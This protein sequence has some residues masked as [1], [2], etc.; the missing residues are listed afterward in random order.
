L[1]WNQE[2]LQVVGE[3]VPEQ[4]QNVGKQQ[5]LNDRLQDSENVHDIAVVCDFLV[6]SRMLVEPLNHWKKAIIGQEVHTDA[7]EPDQAEP[8]EVAIDLLLFVVSHCR[9][10]ELVREC[11]DEEAE[12]L[13][14]EDVV[15]RYL[16]ETTNWLESLRISVLRKERDYNLQQEE[17]LRIL[18]D[19]TDP[20]QVFTVLIIKVRL[21]LFE[22]E[23][24]KVEI[25]DGHQRG[26]DQNYNLEYFLEGAVVLDDVHWWLLFALALVIVR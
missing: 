12:E 14:V 16:L 2:L 25:E 15:L 24:N 8:Q 7:Q 13:S 5:R 22:A 4:T 6:S 1:L 3:A 20:G 17:R 19:L 18:D 9:C 23:R 11:C 26:N 10:E 21:E